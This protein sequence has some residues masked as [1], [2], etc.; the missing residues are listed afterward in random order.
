MAMTKYI[1]ELGTKNWNLLEMICGE[2]VSNF[3]TRLQRVIDEGDLEFDTDGNM[4]SESDLE[5]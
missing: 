4:S 5:L 3:Q 2:F 1:I